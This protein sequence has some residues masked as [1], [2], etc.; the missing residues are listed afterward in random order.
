[1]AAIAVVMVGIGV[2]LCYEAYENKTPHPLT[3]AT[4]AATTGIPKKG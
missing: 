3:K 1:M 2:Y 4:Q